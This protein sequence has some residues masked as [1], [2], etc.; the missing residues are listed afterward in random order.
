[1]FTSS[2]AKG[3]EAPI[4]LGPSK[5]ANLKNWASP[6]LH[7]VVLIY[8]HV[9]EWLQTRFGLVTVFID[10]FNTWL[11]TTL[12]YSAI[13]HLHTLQITTAPPKSVQTPVS[14]AVVP[15]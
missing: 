15:W 1:M 11:V 5:R 8:C 9:T 3:G 7:G 6:I 10:H 12:N 4:Q 2:G 13:A 14:S